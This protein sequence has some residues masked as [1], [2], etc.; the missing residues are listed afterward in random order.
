MRNKGIKTK[1]INLKRRKLARKYKALFGM[2]TNVKIF[3]SKKFKKPNI[4]KIYKKT[5]NH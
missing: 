3:F 5:I 2:F 1:V 4:R